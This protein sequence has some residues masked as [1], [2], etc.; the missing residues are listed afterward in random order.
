M[1]RI[2]KFVSIC[3]LALSTIVCANSDSVTSDTIYEH[4]ELWPF[5]VKV[6]SKAAELK[7][8]G[9]FAGILNRID[10]D[11]FAWIDF[12]RDGLHRVLL[13]HTD[14]LEDATQIKKG[15]VVKEL[16]NFVR[17]TT[18]MFVQ[19]RGPSDASLLPS[20]DLQSADFLLVTYCPESW[21]KEAS[22]VEFLTE[23]TGSVRD[24]NVLELFV[25]TDV[26]F[27][28]TIVE[29]ELRDINMML[30]H[31][32]I[33]QVKALGHTPVKG[34]ALTCVL[35]DANGKVYNRWELERSQN[36]QTHADVILTKIDAL[37]AI[38]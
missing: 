32:A 17:S 14:I 5:Y 25:A 10:A 9:A 38:D 7:V 23:L 20:A 31:M 28:N 13:E 30:P 2:N 15:A 11:D 36:L 8:G 6:D 1:K 16:P 35:I 22:L 18:N 19:Y 33:A 3:F 24:R 21:L 27:Y 34:D 12:G 26:R 29:C 4:S 37:V